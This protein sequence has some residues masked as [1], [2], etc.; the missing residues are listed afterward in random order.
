M[1]AGTVLAVV[2]AVTA[3]CSD[4][5][6]PLSDELSRYTDAGDG[7]QQVVSAITYADS[8][9]K[10]AGQERYQTFDAAVRSKLA[11]VSGTV[12]LEVRDLPSDRVLE[13]ARVVASLA[14]RTAAPEARGAR[15]VGLLR[16]YRR[17][18]MQLVLDCSR[19]V[20][21]L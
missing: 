10:A 11:A 21:G 8:S 17:E 20:P 13:Q 5:E 15:R 18:A 12:A 9:L 4:D 3:G 7:C 16:E 1:L 19:E 6:P 2:C 14:D